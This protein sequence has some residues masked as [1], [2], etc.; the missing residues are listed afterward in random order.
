MP[1]QGSE[2]P[3]SDRGPARDRAPVGRGD[4]R[5]THP[6]HDTGPRQRPPRPCDPR[7]HRVQRRRTALAGDRPRSLPADAPSRSPAV[8]A[9]RT[10]HRVVRDRGDG[11]RRALGDRALA[12]GLGGAVAPIVK[13]PKPLPVPSGWWRP[14]RATDVS[15]RGSTRM[16]PRRALRRLRD[17]PS[18][19]DRRIPSPCGA[20]S[21]TGARPRTATSTW[22][23]TPAYAYRVRAVK[24]PRVRRFGTEARGRHAAA[25]PHLCRPHRR[26][27][28]AAR[29]R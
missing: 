12:R 10:R 17:L 29:C 7:P 28:P 8:T 21:T 24:G 14:R 3:L 9:G 11:V 5:P 2:H 4:A 15:P 13:G 1:R 27:P 6:G 23:S 16:D 20:Q 19:G 18:R 26:R 22:A 25:L